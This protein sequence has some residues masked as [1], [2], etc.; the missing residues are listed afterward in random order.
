[1]LIRKLLGMTILFALSMTSGFGQTESFLI[2]F[3]K[4]WKHAA[5]YTLEVATLMPAE[6]YDYRPTPEQKSFKEQ[7]LHILSNAVW[8]SSSYLGGEVYEADLK[9]TDYS[10]EDMLNLL[11]TT[12]QYTQKVLEEFTLAELDDPVQFFNEEV[13]KKGQILTLLND[14]HTHHRGQLLV[15]LRLNGITPPR[16]K[17]W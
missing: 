16:Y 5:A 2:D 12:F 10:K 15:Y 14:H 1:M 17:G 9:R 3:Q 11:Q 6:A 7:L 4:K 13:N 8:L